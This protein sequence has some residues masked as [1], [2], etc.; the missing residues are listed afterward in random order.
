M[1]K[2]LIA[3]ATVAIAVIVIVAGILVLGSQGERSSNSMTWEGTY[4][5]G[6]FVEYQVNS[7][8]GNDTIMKIIVEISSGEA[9]VDM[10]M[11]GQPS[12][13]T[14]FPINGTLAFGSWPDFNMYPQLADEF[15]LVGNESVDTKWGPLIC[16]HL[17]YTGTG[18]DF[19]AWIYNGIVIKTWFTNDLGEWMTEM[20]VDTN[21]EEVVSG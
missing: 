20:L 15:V 16:Q 5:V 18:Q 10:E 1:D 9:T 12:Q 21:L 14:S 19:D 11:N 8:L 3:G 13:G 17:N 4:E 7:T 2:R 6:D